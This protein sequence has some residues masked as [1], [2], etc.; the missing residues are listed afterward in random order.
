MKKPVIYFEM[1]TLVYVFY[2]YIAVLYPIDVIACVLYFSFV[3]EYDP[4]IGKYQF[5]SNIYIYISYMDI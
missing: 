4:T 2:W 1:C 5:A 3:E